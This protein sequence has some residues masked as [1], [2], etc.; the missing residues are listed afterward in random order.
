MWSG[1]ERAIG[2]LARRGK[3]GVEQR[4]SKTVTGRHDVDQCVITIVVCDVVCSEKGRANN[5]VKG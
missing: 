1:G 4:Y 3:D 2:V 5:K